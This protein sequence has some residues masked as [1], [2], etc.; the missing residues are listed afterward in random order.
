M[1]NKRNV[2]CGIMAVAMC[3]VVTAQGDAPPQTN[4]PMRELTEDGVPT[5][6]FFDTFKRFGQSYEDPVTK[7]GGFA[8]LDHFQT[9]A[10]S[11]SELK[12]YRTS[13]K[14]PYSVSAGL[15]RRHGPESVIEKGE[16]RYFG[17]D[18]YAVTNGPAVN[19]VILDR[20]GRIVTKKS[21]SLV[22]LEY[23]H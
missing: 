5:P 8:Q 11:A 17:G 2:L 7:D 4:A 13:G 9:R 16:C 14:V 20:L 23:S 6:E 15:Y 3:A 10:L 12:A 19:Y 18:L 21:V 22:D 1:M